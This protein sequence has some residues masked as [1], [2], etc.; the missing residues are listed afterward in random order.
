MPVAG[1]KAVPA[2][3]LASGWA[4]QAKLAKAPGE[5]VSVGSDPSRVKS[6]PLPLKSLDCFVWVAIGGVCPHVPDAVTST[7]TLTDWPGASAFVVFG[8]GFRSRTVRVP[9]GFATTSA[10]HVLPWGGVM[11]EALIGPRGTLRLVGTVRFAEPSDWVLFCVQGLA[12][13]QFVTRTVTGVAAP[14]GM[15]AGFGAVIVVEYHF[16]LGGAHADVSPK[17][18]APSN[19]TMAARPNRTR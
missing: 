14:A 11:F 5:T 4:V 18:N 9:F 1:V 6:L 19:A 16:V 13:P 10:D 3:W 2:V 8:P 12:V 7:V 17:V 15:F